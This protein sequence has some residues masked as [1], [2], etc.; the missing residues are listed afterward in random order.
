V[1]SASLLRGDRLE[2]SEFTPDIGEAFDRMVPPIRAIFWR[3]SEESLTKHRNP[4]FSEEYGVT[5]QSCIQVDW[6]HTMSLGVFGDFVAKLLQQLVANNAWQVQG[7]PEVRR[8]VSFQRLEHE[9]FQ[10]YKAEAARGVQ[11]SRAQRLDPRMMGKP[12]APACNLHAGETN[13]LLA[14]SLVLVR[15]YGHV[16]VDRKVWQDT[17]AQVQ[18]VKELCDMVPQMFKPCHSQDTPV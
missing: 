15:K 12:D 11:H 10:F 5:P 4:L 17:A 3:P 9:L 1:P 7:S 13:G 8:Q 16:L 14:F 2:P 18:R 6:M